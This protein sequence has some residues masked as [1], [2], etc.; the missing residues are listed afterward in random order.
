MAPR[1]EMAES[2]QV[3]TLATYMLP[4]ER[5]LRVMMEW[6]DLIEQSADRASRAAARLAPPPQKPARKQLAR[7]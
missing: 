7:G 1:H 5:Q 4:R 2:L 3:L 6:L